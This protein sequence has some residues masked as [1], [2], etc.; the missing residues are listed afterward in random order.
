MTPR[1][2]KARPKLGLGARF[3]APALRLAGLLC[4]LLVLLAVARSSRR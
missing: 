1:D 4:A 2:R 3:L